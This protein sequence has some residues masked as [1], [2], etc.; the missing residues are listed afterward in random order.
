MIVN[1]WKI[2]IIPGEPAMCPPRG[3]EQA[4]R[5]CTEITH[6]LPRGFIPAPGAVASVPERQ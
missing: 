3:W 5:L 6:D 1:R 4:G 2:L